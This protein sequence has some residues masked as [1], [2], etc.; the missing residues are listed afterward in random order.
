M[1]ILLFDSG[2]YIYWDILAALRD[3]GHSCQTIYYHFKDRY[4]DLFFEERLEQCLTETAYDLMF[5]IN[6]FPLAARVCQRC[7]I[8]YISWSYDSPLDERLQDYFP[9]E[10]NQI[11]LFDRSEAIAYQGKGFQ[12]V[13][14][15]P[16]AVNVGR[17]DGLL[18]HP[19]PTQ[20]YCCGISFVGQLYDSP[21]ETLLSPAR[22]YDKGY[23]EGLLQAQMLVYGYYFIE[24]LI[25]DKVLESLNHSYQKLGQRTTALTKQGLSHA[26][27]REITH[28]ERTELLRQAN[29]R[30]DTRLFTYPKPLP[31]GMPANYGPLKYYQQMPFVFRHS[32]L[33]LNITLK[34]IHTGIPL[35]ALDIMGC[36][37][38]LLSNY[39]P[40]L[41][42]I[43]EDGKD[44]I[45]Y[46]SIEDALEK[47]DFYLKRDGLREKIARN[48]YQK[49]RE[50]FT[51]PSR[52]AQIFSRPI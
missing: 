15:L 6:F 10:M 50:R 39:Q 5:S 44:A 7:H 36:R 37:G 29:R 27:A 34:D 49:V 11:Y 45:L 18:K 16:L 22:D 28:K 21:L 40:E 19:V 35:R 25:S 47:M 38:A 20:D 1:K 9:Y 48:G 4:E 8:K 17:L 14:H 46:E 12:N 52:L 13:H 2:S 51:Y 24:S 33:N 42:E 32:K 41:A 31:E 26:L 3:M 30:F 23:L 43:F